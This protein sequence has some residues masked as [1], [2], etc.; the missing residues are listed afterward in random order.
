MN[1]ALMEQVVSALARVKHI[2]RESIT[3]DSTL[4]SL[5]LDSLDTITLLFE[6]EEA[7]GVTI[8]DDWLRTVRTTGDVVDG[9]RQLKDL[10]A[11][12]S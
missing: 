5:Q 9:I 1:D 4:E 6:L 8:P 12:G 2:P 10:A 7:V 11:A 3:R